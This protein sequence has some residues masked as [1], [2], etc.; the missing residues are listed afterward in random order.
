MVVVHGHSF[1]SAVFMTPHFSYKTKMKCTHSPTAFT[2]SKKCNTLPI[3]YAGFTQKGVNE[4]YTGK[5]FGFRSFQILSFHSAAS[6]SKEVQFIHSFSEMAKNISLLNQ[7]INCPPYQ[8]LI[9]FHISFF[10]PLY[11]F[12]KDAISL[13]ILGMSTQLSKLIIHSLSSHDSG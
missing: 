4:K 9:L 10:A 2:G 6:N 13:F 3:I 12:N 11:L 5:Q 7:L 8:L 1:H